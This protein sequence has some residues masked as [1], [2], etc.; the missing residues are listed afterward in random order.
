MTRRVGWLD[1]SCGASGDML[2]GALVGAGVPLDVI[3]TAVDTLG[4]PVRFEV[5]QVRRAGLAATKVDVVAPAGDAVRT[6]ADI[7]ALLAGAPLAE[8]VRDRAT[9][10]FAALAAAEARV[11]GIAP[12]EVHF[13]EVGALDAIADVVGASAGLAHLA[14]DELVA[15]PVALGGGRAMTAHGVLPV[16]VPAVLELLRAAGA[17]AAGGPAQVELCTPTGAAIVVTAATGYGQ[18]P[19]LR[20]T[21][22][23]A[24]AGTR[25]L[26]GRPNIVRVVVGEALENADG[27][28]GR[29][30]GGSSG[31]PVVPP[32]TGRAHDGHS[33]GD[34]DHG[35]HSHGGHSHG[36]HSHDGHSHGRD[37]ESPAPPAPEMA[38]QAAGIADHSGPWGLAESGRPGEPGDLVATDELVLEANVDDLDPRVWPSVL[39]ALL[40]AGAVDAWL[41]PILMKK[42]RPAH[43]LRALVPVAAAPAVRAAVFAHTSTLGLRETAVRKHALARGVRVVEV[44]GHAIRV[45]VS[46]GL[47]SARAGD[48]GAG[49]QDTGGQDAG[50]R[51]AGNQGAGGVAQPEWEDVALVADRLGWPARRVLAAANALAHRGEWSDVSAPADGGPAP[52]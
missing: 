16:P 48:H 39:A 30:G 8:P 21:A 2:L 49:S 52:T 18:L 22:V 40:A 44:A 26:P 37:H 23:G 34:H 28:R 24:G 46:P 3:A 7:R 9:A 5:R 4:L 1:L 31:A 10:I 51:S 25:D 14:L 11:H 42:G 32:S 15:T 20:V 6:W 29:Q 12:D 41:T 19:P 33:R 50:S 47:P 17:P 35:G 13:H 43:T 38:D 45:K 36:G 27:G